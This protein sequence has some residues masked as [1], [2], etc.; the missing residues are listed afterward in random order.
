MRT[1]VAIFCASIILSSPAFAGNISPGSTTVG[2]TLREYNNERREESMEKRLKKR[3]V[4]RPT[5]NAPEL[6]SLPD[7][8]STIYVIRIIVQPDTSINDKVKS[9]IIRTIAEYEGQNLSLAQMKKIAYLITERHG[10]KTSKA[11]I[12]EQSFDENILYVNFVSS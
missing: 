9:D 10:A 1:I 8:K 6:S 7:G 4:K 11:Y 2:S 3:A 5:M 12:P